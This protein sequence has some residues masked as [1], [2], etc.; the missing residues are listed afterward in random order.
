MFYLPSPEFVWEHIFMVIGMICAQ[1]GKEYT[2][3][4]LK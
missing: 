2:E 3:N 4:V 1:E